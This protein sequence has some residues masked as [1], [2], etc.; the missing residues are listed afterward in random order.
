[1]AFGESDAEPPLLSH[2][3][4]ALQDSDAAVRE[5]S[6]MAYWCLSHRCPKASTRIMEGLGPS[7]Q[8][9]LQ[10]SLSELPAPQSIVRGDGKGIALLTGEEPAAAVVTGR[11]RPRTQGRERKGGK[12]GRSAKKGA[13]AP[14]VSLKSRMAAA[15]KEKAAAGLDDMEVQ[16]LA[17][18][19]PPSLSEDEHSEGK[20]ASGS[21]GNGDGSADGG[22]DS[23]SNGSAGSTLNAG[24]K[25]W[26]P[27]STLDAGAKEWT[28]Q[29][30]GIA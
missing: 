27:A 2:M 12:A 16:V 10:L 26:T 1:M 24:A 29:A 22:A 17:P 5:S 9:R 23:T 11:A 21:D 25:E 19:K 15:R 28:P 18:P 14:R 3:S 20:A 8:R 13:G 7:A 6:R 30:T 4:Q